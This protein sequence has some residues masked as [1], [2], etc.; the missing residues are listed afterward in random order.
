MSLEER[1]CGRGQEL[2]C[3][4]PESCKNI[5]KELVQPGK[6]VAFYQSPVHDTATVSDYLTIATGLLLQSKNKV[7]LRNLSMVLRQMGKDPAEKAKLT[8]ESVEKAKE[9]VQ[10][11]ISD[12]TSWCK[13]QQHE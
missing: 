8:E 3:W 9:A 10:L 4:C 6:S 5:V 1:R 12:G 7:A 13:L 2:F 11:D